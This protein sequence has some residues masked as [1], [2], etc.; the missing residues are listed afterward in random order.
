MAA[1][2]CH[3][4]EGIKALFAVP[5]ARGLDL[6]R[7]LSA[8][9]ATALSLAAYLS[10][11]DIVEELLKAGADRTAVQDHGATMLHV[12][13]CNPEA[14]HRM[15]DL[16]LGTDG[17]VDVNA[18]FQPLTRKWYLIDVLFMTMARCGDRSAFTVEMAHTRG[19]TALHQAAAFGQSHLVEWL[20]A[21]GAKKSLGIKNKMGAT[22]LDSARI[23]GPHPEVES[24]LSAA[25]L[26]AN[27]TSKYKVRRGSRMAISD[28]SLKGDQAGEKEGE[29]TAAAPTPPSVAGVA[30]AAGAEDGGAEVLGEFADNGQNTEE[31]SLVVESM[32]DGSDDQRPTHTGV[33]YKESGALER[34]GGTM[35]GKLG[36]V[37]GELGDVLAWIATENE[38][39]ER[40]GSEAA[41][42]PGEQLGAMRGKLGAVHGKLGAVLAWIATEDDSSGS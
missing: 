4:S 21:H 39:H 20:L 16:L 8:N 38:A 17:K 12:A 5:A 35:R 34:D 11:T 7:G 1:I 9:N 33:S 23:F 25:M 32:E 36:A 15:L 18:V 10:R 31:E 37:H 29:G 13:C 22:P 24:L 6:E 19:S 2:V 14:D 27:F 40:G 26:E 28:V 41:W 30:A 3:N 42:G